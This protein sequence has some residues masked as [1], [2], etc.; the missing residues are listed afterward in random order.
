MNVTVASSGCSR[1][2]LSCAA[3]RREELLFCVQT[4]PRFVFCSKAKLFNIRTQLSSTVDALAT[5]RMPP[6]HVIKIIRAVILLAA[7]V[8]AESTYKPNQVKQSEH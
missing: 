1:C 6:R 8:H 4:F 7:V 2:D 5:C 3:Y